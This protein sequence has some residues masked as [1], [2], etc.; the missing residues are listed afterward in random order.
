MKETKACMLQIPVKDVLAAYVSAILSVTDMP[1]FLRDVGHDGLID[2]VEGFGDRD[3]EEPGELRCATIVPARRRLHA[4]GRS[5]RGHRRPARVGS[6]ARSTSACSADRLRR[7][8]VHHRQGHRGG[9][10]DAGDALT[11]WTSQDSSSPTSFFFPDKCAR[12]LRERHYDYYQPA[13][14]DDRHL[15]RQDALIN[16]EIDRYTATRALL[17]ATTSSSWRRCPASTA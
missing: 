3:P 9:Q 4:E 1:V 15:H 11:K 2:A 5:A 17:S 13:Y 8:D 16:D 7:Q 6:A 10:P 12:L 14:P